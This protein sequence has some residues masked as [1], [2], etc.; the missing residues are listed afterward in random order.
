MKLW[1]IRH[2]MTKGNQEHRYVGTTGDLC[3]YFLCN[4]ERAILAGNLLCLILFNR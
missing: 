3:G 1:L 4:C 2:G